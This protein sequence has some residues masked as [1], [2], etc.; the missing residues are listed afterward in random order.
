MEEDVTQESSTEEVVKEVPETD[1]QEQNA[2]TQSETQIIPTPEVTGVPSDVD[3][4]GVPFKN[5]YYEMKRKY[6]DVS[7]KQ[8]QILQKVDSLQGQQQQ[9]KHSKEELMAYISKE[10][11]EPAHRAWALNEINKLEEKNVSEKIE[12]KFQALQKQQ[13]A[14][15]VKNET[16][17]FV[18]QRH[19]E[20]TI[21]DN[22]GNFVGW[23]TRSPLVQRMD[24]YMRN[25]EIANNPAGLRVAL[26]LA[27]DD[28]S[29]GQLANQQKLK[30]Q[31]KTLQKATM[32]EGGETKSVQELDNLSRA[33]DTL[34]KSGTVKDAN[35]A[36]SAW[37]KKQ[38]K[39]EE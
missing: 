7:S 6:E 15:Q 20:I 35:K 18:T 39:F 17:N 32:V 16:F 4:M 22:A 3:E 24:A 23:N 5:R 31:V 30:T 26:A 38:G 2:Q 12:Q 36:V 19:P 34:R 11:T 28:L 14:E 10:D 21:K 37:L 29:G 9:P 13:K 25:P 1:Q 8:D 33:K 27:K